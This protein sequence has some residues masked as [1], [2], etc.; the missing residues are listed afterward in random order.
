MLSP[1]GGKWIFTAIYA[2]DLPEGYTDV[3][4]NLAIDSAGNL[5]GTGVFDLAWHCRG[6]GCQRSM[7]PSDAYYPAPYVFRGAQG[8]NGWQF[9]DTVFYY[10]TNFPAC[11]ALALDAHGYLFG[12]T[13][14]CGKYG[15]GT[16]WQVSPY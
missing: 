3:F 1:S 16:V 4:N 12:T 7:I 14:S 9:W 6:Y 8:T 11:G 13:D 10:D 2:D 15:K 5:Y